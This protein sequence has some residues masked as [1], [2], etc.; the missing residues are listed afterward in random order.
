MF[1]DS[2]AQ[3]VI[4]RFLERVEMQSIRSNAIGHN[5]HVVFPQTFPGLVDTSKG[6]AGYPVHEPLVLPHPSMLEI[7]F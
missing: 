4:A 1:L 5:C 7:S 6:A 3:V 2:M